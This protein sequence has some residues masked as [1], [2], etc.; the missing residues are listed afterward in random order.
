MM[1][2]RMGREGGGAKTIER[3]KEGGM[4]WMNEW[5]GAHIQNEQYL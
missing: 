1:K 3:E 2:G 4:G 5:G